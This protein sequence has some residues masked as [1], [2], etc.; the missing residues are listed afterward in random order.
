A[1]PFTLEAGAVNTITIGAP[2]ARA[3]QGGALASVALLKGADAKAQQLFN[4]C[5][6]TLNGPDAPVLVI[7]ELDRELIL[8]WSNPSGSNNYREA[9]VEDYDNSSGGDSAYRFQGYQVFQL[10]DGTVGQTDLYDVD[11]ARL[12]LQC[13]LNDA[14]SQIVN[15]Y[16]NTLLSALEPKQRAWPDYNKGIVHSLNITTDQFATGD[17]RLINHKTYYYAIVAYGYSPTQLPQDLN[18]LVDYLPFIPGRRFFTPTFYNAAIPHISSPEAGGTEKHSS[19]G[20]GPRLKRI[21][22]KGNGGNILDITDQTAAEIVAGPA[23]RSLHPL[24]EN[25]RGPISIKIVDPLNVPAGSFSITL[26]T[27][28]KVT[29]NIDSSRWQ[30]KNLGTGDTVNSETTIKLPNE[31]IINGQAK[32]LSSLTNNLMPKWGISVNATLGVEPGG[33]TFFNNGFLEATMSFSD[34]SLNW[35]TG[36]ADAEGVNQNNWI[37]SGAFKDP[38]NPQYDDYSIYNGTDDV[39]AYEKVLGGTWAPFRLSAYTMAGVGAAFRGGPVWN[40]SLLFT[41][42][43]LKNTA[44]V[45]VVLTADR[46]KWTRCPV[47]ELQEETALAEGGVAKL[48]MR[49]A[50]SVD[51]A[52]R[53]STQAGYN[54]TE[55]DLNG[56][57]GMG[58][59]PGYA[60]NL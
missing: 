22:G 13:D 31:Q 42:N 30:L 10:K 5:F 53:N 45:D 36:V 33:S 43:K 24:Y 20:S 28:P 51:K 40:N 59:F 38:L 41:Q 58:W 12:V 52:G 37:R 8:T 11:K 21:E 34:V 29:G 39:Q 18:Q 35:L 7:Q 16:N 50:L 48:L 55:G 6:S 2:W 32:K 3:T 19:Y 25:G 1:G 47:L 26:Y 44:S 56:T 27:N 54:S 14:V 60:I 15:Y 49:S 46:T 23:Y 4:N 17:N 57:T 9:Y